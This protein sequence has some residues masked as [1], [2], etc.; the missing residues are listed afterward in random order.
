MPVLVEPP[1]SGTQPQDETS[2]RELVQVK[3]GERGDERAPDERQCEGRPDGNPR[4]ADRDR[5]GLHERG[6]MHLAHPKRVRALQ[7]SL[8]GDRTELRHRLTPRTERESGHHGPYS[9]SLG[10]VPPR[11]AARAISRARR[12]KV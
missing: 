12:L 9:S 5:G 6:P 4:C 3:R 8:R 11:S 10:R 2:A 7:L 1:H